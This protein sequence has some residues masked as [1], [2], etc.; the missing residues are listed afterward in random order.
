MVLWEVMVPTQMNGKRVKTKHHKKWDKKIREVSGGLTI[1]PVAKG[2]WDGKDGKTDIELMLPVRIA[3]TSSEIQLILEITKKH[4]E[5]QAVMA[6]AVS[7]SV[8]IV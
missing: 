8:I 1:L 5:Q 4:Y 3:C 7:S 6:Y 2:Q